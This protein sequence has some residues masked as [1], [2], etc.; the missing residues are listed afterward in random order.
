MDWKAYISTDPQ[1]T[2]GAVCFRGTR[3]PVSV[4]LDNLASGE[5]LE[6]ILDHYSSLRPEH[7]S[8]ALGYAAD[9]ARERIVPIPA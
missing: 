9:L 4:V 3:I 1:I 6:P 5:T 7:I 8:A 2:H